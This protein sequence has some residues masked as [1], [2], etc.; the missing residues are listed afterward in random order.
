MTN[1][2]L[3]QDLVC[4]FQGFGD[5]RSCRSTDDNGH[6]F[7]EV[8]TEAPLSRGEAHSAAQATRFDA[9]HERIQS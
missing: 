9:I 3:Y 1:C 8:F 2:R 6:T 7:V 5:I 4:V